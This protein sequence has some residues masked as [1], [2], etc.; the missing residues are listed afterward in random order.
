MEGAHG[1]TSG[2]WEGKRKTAPPSPL[3]Q[4]RR[5]AQRNITTGVGKREGS[6]LSNLVGR[7][8]L[9]CEGGIGH[10]KRNVKNGRPRHIGKG[11]R[12]KNHGH[13]R[14]AQPKRKKGRNEEVLSASQIC[15]R[16][17]K[18]NTKVTKLRVKK[19]RQNQR[20]P[21]TKTRKKELQALSGP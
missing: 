21:K 8:G 6:T 4:T 20:T 16:N 5:K 17:Y 1:S 11:R 10:E 2:G 13:L 9:L 18:E 19:A 15:S 14:V 7:G 12:R 3:D